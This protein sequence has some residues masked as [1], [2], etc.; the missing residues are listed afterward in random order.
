ML[1]GDGFII[2]GNNIYGGMEYF[3]LENLYLLNILIKDINVK[4]KFMDLN[5]LFE[6]SSFIFN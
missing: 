6:K 4:K 5:I 2:G 1:F 3:V